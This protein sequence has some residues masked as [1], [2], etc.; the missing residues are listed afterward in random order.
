[1]EYDAVVDLYMVSVSVLQDSCYVGKISDIQCSAA[2]DCVSGSSGRYEK[3]TELGHVASNRHGFLEICRSDG[4]I[5][6][7][8]RGHGKGSASGGAEGDSAGGRSIGGTT[9]SHLSPKRLQHLSRHIGAAL[10]SERY[11]AYYVNQG[12]LQDAPVFSLGC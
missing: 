11:L 1:M 2:S 9:P 7:G 8:E 3:R 5:R 10:N 12:K 4:R 6:D